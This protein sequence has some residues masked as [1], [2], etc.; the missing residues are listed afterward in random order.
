VIG[1]DFRTFLFGSTQVRY[2]IQRS[3][4]RKTVNI[5]IDPAEGVVVTAPRDVDDA[6]VQEIVVR[7][8]GWVVERLQITDAVSKALYY[9]AFVSGESFPYLGRNYRLRVVPQAGAK[10]GVRLLHGRFEVN[11]DA[12]LSATDRRVEIRDGLAR[13]YQE[14]AVSRLCERVDLLAPRLG[15]T[16]PPVLVR[17]QKKRW[18]S[19]DH[20]GRLRFNWRIVMAPMSL[21]DYVVAHELCHLIQRDHSGAFWQL[22][23]IALP[24][25]EERRQRL[26]RE[27]PRFE[28]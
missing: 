6:V 3:G 15:V 14:R 10:V 8:A 20:Q 1:A 18:A 13:W 17:D 2:R 4:R 12:D 11:V 25:Y 9:P 24:D 19:C 27:G 5:S 23:R 21:V 16:A 28:L 7:R 26:R 22:L